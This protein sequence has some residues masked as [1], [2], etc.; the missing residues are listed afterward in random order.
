M[1]NSWQLWN[2]TWMLEDEPKFVFIWLHGWNWKCSYF[3]V[4]ICISIQ[5]VEH[6]N[7]IQ[8]VEGSIPNST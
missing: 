6:L 5:L 2:Y 8:E 4:Y 1:N 3:V 7:G